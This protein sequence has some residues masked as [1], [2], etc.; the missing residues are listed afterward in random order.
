MFRSLH[1]RLWLSYAFVIAAALSIVAIAIFVF[2]ANDN[3]QNS[4]Q[5]NGTLNTLI[6]RQSTSN[7]RQ[8]K[9][10][11][12]VDRI[13]ESTGLRIFAYTSQGELLAD[14]RHG[15][16]AEF[17][18]NQNYPF[19]ERRHP[20]LSYTDSNGKTWKYGARKFD[21]NLIVIAAIQREPLKQILNSNALD[22]LI[23][24]V[25]RAGWVALLMALLFAY[26]MSRWI[27]RP[28]F[29]MAKAVR[30]MA[31]GQK[32]EVELEGPN[33]V[34][35]LG[36]AFNEMSQQ[37]TSSQKSQRDFVAN[38]SHELKTPLTSIQGFAQAVLDGTAASQEAVENSAQI[39]Y[40]ESGR[41]HRLVVDLL[42]LA[43]FDAGTATIQLDS[44]DLRLMLES[45]L[46]KLTPQADQAMVELRSEIGIMPKFIGDGDRL[47][48]VFMNLIDNAIKHTPI[49]GEVKLRAEKIEDH[50]RISV[51]DTGEGIPPD[52]VNRIFERF[53]QIDKART[54]DEERGVGLGLAIAEQIVKGHGGK[55]MVI[56]EVSKGSRFIVDLP[57]K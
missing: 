55:M 54:R 8:I 12:L 43:K 27:A 35:E 3:P 49:G 4:I 21:N 33:E 38:V 1:W 9:I 10:V 50:L 44:I 19:D 51:I 53:Y 25:F 5:I 28:L 17:E 45:I 20:I 32:T 30:G 26:L 37:V 34:Q 40:D 57:I 11:D 48:Q 41:M 18:H 15:T 6:E 14:S 56:S 29:N 31:E 42:D 7:L 13:D 47:A 39:I 16:E 52:E 24:P 46:E 36:H 23:Q 22:E 2:L